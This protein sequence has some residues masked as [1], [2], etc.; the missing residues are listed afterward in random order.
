[1]ELK[2][3]WTKLYTIRYPENYELS[4]PLFTYNKGEILLA[5]KSTLGIYDPKN[6]SI[7]YPE[8]PDDEVTGFYDRIKAELCIKSLVCPDLPN[9]DWKMSELR[10]TCTCGSGRGPRY[11]VL[12]CV[13]SR[14]SSEIVMAQKQIWS[15]LG[16]G[17]LL[18]LI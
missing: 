11:T 14:N 7:T 8:V 17:S 13:G 12:I 16:N 6:D 4:L 5:F 2:R 15:E 1:M 10:E 9:E 18:L 3:L